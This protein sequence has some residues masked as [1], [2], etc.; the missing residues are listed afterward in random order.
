MKK[1]QVPLKRNIISKFEVWPYDPDWCI[2]NK[3][4]KCI[5]CISVYSQT[6]NINFDYI[7]GKAPVLYVVLLLMG[8]NKH[9]R[10]IVEEDVK[11]IF[12]N[13][14]SLLTRVND[15][16]STEIFLAHNGENNLPVIEKRVV[17]IES[18]D[19]EVRG[20]TLSPLEY[21]LLVGEVDFNLYSWQDRLHELRSEYEF[22]YI[23]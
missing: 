16:T 6:R 10:K 21:F 23:M 14:Y 15:D 20:C 17:H 2:W 13:N 4:Q 5:G 7:S 1:T 3:D 19:H 18:I 22:R 8:A 9:W 11:G 12:V